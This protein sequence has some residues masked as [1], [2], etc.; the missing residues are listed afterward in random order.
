M[1]GIDLTENIGLGLVSWWGQ[2]DAFS[3]SYAW[4]GDYKVIDADLFAAI[5]ANDARK[6]QFFDNPASGRH[7]QPLFK[8]YASNRIGGTSRTVTADYVYMRVEEAYLLNAEANARTGNDVA[9]RNSLKAVVS[10]RVPDASYID[11]LSGQALAD[12]AY[13]QTR[14]ELWGEGK[15]FF[16]LKRNQATIVRG[17]NHLSFVGVP[18]PYN[19]ER[20]QFEIPQDEIQ[21]N[22][23]VN[24]QNQ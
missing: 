3:Y 15:S 11:G 2:V 23:F 1:W 4:A 5:P 13:L 19:D 12:E 8:F 17:A 16:A 9:A 7:L 6:A 22:P 20:L 18:I 14:I 21:N 24:S 10:Q